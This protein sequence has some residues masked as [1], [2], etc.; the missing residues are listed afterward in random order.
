MSSIINSSL[1]QAYLPTKALLHT[2]CQGSAPYSL[3][4]LCFILPVKALLHSPR[5]GSAPHSLSGLCSILS[6][7]ALL[8]SLSKT[9]WQTRPNLFS[10]TPLAR[11]ETLKSLLIRFQI[12]FSMD[13][14]KIQ[15]RVGS[16]PR[17]RIWGK[18]STDSIY[19]A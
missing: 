6:T 15:F 9:Q 14:I 17:R 2:P 4:S 16:G 13:S 5:Q 8:H 11:S 1:F 19:K 10:M 12:I 18:A 3:S 7:K